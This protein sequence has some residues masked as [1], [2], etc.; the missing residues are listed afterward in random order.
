MSEGIDYVY[1][2]EACPSRSGGLKHT[3]RDGRC[4]DCNKVCYFAEKR[5]KQIPAP[6]SDTGDM[7]A[8]LSALGISNG[9]NGELAPDCVIDHES[10]DDGSTCGRCGVRHEARRTVLGAMPTGPAYEPGRSWKGDGGLSRRDRARLTFAS[11][12]PGREVSP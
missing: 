6:P 1:D 9:Q 8:R 4:P 12:H 10:L 11:M 5:T 3:R 7:N 2:D